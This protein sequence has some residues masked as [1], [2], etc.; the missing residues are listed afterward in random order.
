MFG[1]GYFGA[2]Y[3]G[4][5]YF[6]PAGSAAAATTFVGSYFDVPGKEE[7]AVA[8]RKWLEDHGLEPKAAQ[9]IEDVALRQAQELDLEEQ[10]R[11]EELDK[12]LRARSIRWHD[13]YLEM[14]NVQRQRIIDEEIAS[15]LR[16]LEADNDAIMVIAIVA[17]L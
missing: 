13:N 11:F 4:D 16:Q 8:A 12:A 17:M 2:G 15:R 1:N 6:G 10:Q 7:R 3:Y 14:L 9:I 5:G